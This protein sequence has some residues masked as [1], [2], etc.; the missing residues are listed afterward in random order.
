MVWNSVRCRYMVS[1]YCY[2]FNKVQNIKG[3]ATKI[4]FSMLL[5]QKKIFHALKL[6]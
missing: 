6:G 4:I 1:N 3:P 5:F 2:C